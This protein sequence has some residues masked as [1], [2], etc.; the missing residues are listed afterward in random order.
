M[1]RLLWLTLVVRDD[2]KLSTSS[3][4][5]CWS[6]L[7]TFLLILA[8]Y[9]CQ[10]GRWTNRWQAILWSLYQL[11]NL[12]LN[13][14]KMILVIFIELIYVSRLFLVSIYPCNLCNETPFEFYVEHEWSFKNRLLSPELHNL[15]LNTETWPLYSLRTRSA[16]SHAL[17]TQ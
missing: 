4:W 7:G 5:Y 14:K 11:H 8:E 12:Q 3:S 10:E 17:C 15:K 6:L 1:F 9:S 2:N 13:P 16:V